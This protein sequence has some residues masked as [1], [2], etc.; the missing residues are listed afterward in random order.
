MSP[1]L[2]GVSGF[3]CSSVI[4]ST[5]AIALPL[6]PALS[7]NSNLNSPFFVKVCVFVPPLLVMVISSLS[8]VNVAITGSNVFWVVL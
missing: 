8:P 6:F 1:I 5:F 4:Q 2:T 7:W 3:S